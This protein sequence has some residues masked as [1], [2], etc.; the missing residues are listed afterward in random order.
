MTRSPPS[1]EPRLPP[2]V[3]LRLLAVLALVL[4]P[5]LPRLPAWAALLVVV[6][7]VWRTLAALRG[8]PLLPGKLRVLLTLGA[9]AGVYASFGSVSGQTA[10]VAL[11]TVMAAL[12]LSELDR[13]RDLM[14]MVFLLYFL[15][16]THFLF[17][18]ELWTAAYLLTVATLITALLIDANHPGSVLPLR[19]GL[20]MASRLLLRA[21][22]LMALMF[23]L[24]PR[25]PGPIWGLPAD[26][27]AARSGLSDSMAPG[28]IARLVG[29]DAVAFRVRFD[30]AVPPPSERY[31]RGPVFKRFDGRRWDSGSR[32]IA[33]LAPDAELHGVGYRYELTLEPTRT[34]WLFALDLPAR[35]GLPEDARINA[36]HQLVLVRGEVR[37]RRRYR[38][39]SH[40]G[41][42]L[43]RELPAALRAQTLLLPPA[44][45]PRATALGRQWRRVASDDAA[46]VEKALRL[47]REQPFH[48]T[49][50]PPT[51]SRDPVDAFLFDSRRGFCEHF[52]SSFAVLMRAAGIPARV[53]TGYL[54]GERNAIGDYWIVRQSDAHAWTEVWLAGRGWLRI[55]P[56]A[57]VAPERIERGIGS[58]LDD[59]E[60]PDF[61][62][63]ATRSG[64][65]FDLR[66]RWDWLNARW[67][68]W[69][70][71]YGPELQAELLQRFGLDGVRDMLLVLTLL[72][73]SALAGFGWLLLWQSRVHHPVDDTLRAWRRLQKKLAR[74]GL[75]QG[76]Q[77]G[78]RDYVSRVISARPDLAPAL[79]Q[80]LALYL[81][82]R[83]LEGSDAERQRALENAIGA[84]T[85]S[86][87]HGN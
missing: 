25:L 43:Q 44:S 27:G 53:V 63:P 4:A 61:L 19:T 68:Q 52:A 37:E 39:Q 14:V 40:A 18:Q 51:A 58:A 3:Q 36:D 70:L 35:T 15:L 54:G 79:A 71:G 66:A 7:L 26:A 57:A 28:E 76:D 49:L 59:A 29:S 16:I 73:S 45:N 65:R 48:Y 78:P 69:V 62:N 82:L 2:A 77:E 83:Y 38:L 46:I 24:F 55:D 47:F 86:A 34:P 9:F 1:P 75:V 22:P 21:L 64:F 60:L 32:A 50:N 11:I 67:N 81:Q 8:W 84:F 10:G 23:V 72:I 5:H 80:L 41:Y 13:R 6:M 17:S 31:W 87:R 12:K 74:I 85:A 56:T 20:T 42:R 33:D 30:G